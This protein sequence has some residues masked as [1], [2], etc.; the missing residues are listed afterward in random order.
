[1]ADFVEQLSSIASAADVA[2]LG[3]IT[4]ISEAIKSD[5]SRGLSAAQV[6]ANRA[7]Y[8]S[9]R[10]PSKTQRSFFSHLMEAF[11]DTTLKI[12]VVSAVF[13]M[14]F[15]LFLSKTTADIIQG[16]AILAAVVIVSGRS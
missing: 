15:G 12:L 10:L 2:A 6:E 14:G 16:M 7:A 11:E 13:S 9:N 1:M 8:G 3:G 4:A 5:A